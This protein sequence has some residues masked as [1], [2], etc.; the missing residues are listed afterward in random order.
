MRVRTVFQFFLYAQ[1]Y[2]LF[3]ELQNNRGI[4]ACGKEAIVME[5]GII[6]PFFAIG[7]CVIG[8]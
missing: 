5:W 2:T 7:F 6:A 1:K 8:F 3:L 4:N